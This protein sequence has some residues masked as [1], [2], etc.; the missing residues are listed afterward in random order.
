M[1]DFLNAIVSAIFATGASTVLATGAA[2]SASDYL[3]TA[4]TFQAL[5][6]KA[7]DVASMPRASDP[8]MKE[9]LGVLSDERMFTE[10]KYTQADFSTLLDVCGAANTH[11]MAYILFDMKT[12]VTER[13]DFMKMATQIRELSE[14]N[15]VTFQE[16]LS[17]L[18]PFLIRCMASQIALIEEFWDSL[19]SKDRTD[20]RKN[21]AIQARQG[22][23][24]IY[25][26]LLSSLQ[27]EK[28]SD[29]NRHKHARAL[30]DSAQV[31]AQMISLQQR[32]AIRTGVKEVQPKVGAEYQKYLDQIVQAMD[33]KRCGSL[34]AL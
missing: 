15:T 4:K 32:S 31:F 28:I 13:S 18:Q 22:I 9:M 27:L 23:V 1:R 25:V 5:Q 6:A 7:T 30:S 10:R 2:P 33:Q 29:A 24:N 11:N 26:G 16:E 19:S 8:G 3:I 20:I 12:K 14:R 21:G 17:A 34:C